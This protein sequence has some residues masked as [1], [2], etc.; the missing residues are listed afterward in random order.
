[1]E[2]YIINHSEQGAICGALMLGITL[3]KFFSKAPKEV[4]KAISSEEC[5]IFD[6]L[7]DKNETKSFSL[8][9]EEMIILR[10]M[11]KYFAKIVE[12]IRYFENCHIVLAEKFAE[13]VISD[14]LAKESERQIL[15]ITREEIKL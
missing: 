10:Y 1:M 9:L 11:L 12:D 5:K 2:E 8:N 7:E 6:E 4:R 15:K 13:K 14:I 3:R